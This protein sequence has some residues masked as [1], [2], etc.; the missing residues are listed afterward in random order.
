MSAE[1]FASHCAAKFALKLT[2]VVHT[3]GVYFVT[4]RFSVLTLIWR[5]ASSSAFARAQISPV[6][7]SGDTPRSFAIVMHAERTVLSS[8]K[9]ALS[10]AAEA[11][12]NA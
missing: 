7:P 8:S 1:A 5:F 11:T 2:S 10:S 4:R 6:L 9:L 3:G 12:R